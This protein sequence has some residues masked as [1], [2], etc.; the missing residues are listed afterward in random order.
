[1]FQR[2]VAD[3]I[4]AAPGSK[5]YGRLAV[6][7]QW[8]ARATRLFDVPAR[9]FTPPPKVTSRR[10]A[11]AARR[12]RA[13]SRRGARSGHRRRLRPAAQDAP[14]KPEAAL[15]R[16]GADPPV[17]RHRADAP[18]R[19][20]SRRGLSPPRAR[21][22]PKSSRTGS[23]A[24]GLVG[25]AEQALDEILEPR[26]ALAPHALR[27]QDRAHRGKERSRSSLMTT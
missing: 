1:M 3:R 22:A 21:S 7:A 4:V 25:F 24:H 27:R 10:P 23:A 14:L 17:A 16:S 5:A 2:E 9:A 13:A 26:H 11:R 15:A 8:R 12:C 19:G 6:L 18:R 20:P